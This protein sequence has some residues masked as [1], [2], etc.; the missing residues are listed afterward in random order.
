MKTEQ[1]TKLTDANFEREV[2]QSDQPVLVDFWAPWCG[3]CVML[4]PTIEALA[5]DYDGRVKVAKLN[6]DEN[7]ETAAAFGI[8]SIPSVLLFVGG[9]VV[10]QFAGVQPRKVFE[11]ALREVAA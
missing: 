5:K 3:P 8:R 11:A 2:L 6:I 7:P 1:S 10:Q 4:G 9:K